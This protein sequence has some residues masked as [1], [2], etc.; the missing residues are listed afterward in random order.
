MDSRRIQW[1]GYAAQMGE[2]NGTYNV[3]WKTLGKDTNCD[4]RLRRENSKTQK[5]SRNV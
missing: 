3:A 5:Q 2:I 4:P 1:I